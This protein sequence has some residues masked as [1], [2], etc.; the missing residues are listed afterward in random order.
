M[1]GFT[2]DESS[3]STRPMRQLPPSQDSLTRQ[4]DGTGPTGREISKKL[5]D[6]GILAKDTHTWTIRFAPPLTISEADLDVAL[7]TIVDV[8]T[9]AQP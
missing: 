2:I 9:G 8:V 3:D 6:R 7:A 5:L 1:I 4:L